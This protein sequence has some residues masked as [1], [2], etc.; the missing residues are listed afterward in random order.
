MFL[1]KIEDLM[2]ALD[3]KVT[4]RE[5][6]YLFKLGTSKIVSTQKVF[7]HIAQV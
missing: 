5:W 6:K 1:T 3:E 4:W 7:K 2:S